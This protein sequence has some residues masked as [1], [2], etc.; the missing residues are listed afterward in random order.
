MRIG[1][2][3]RRI[4]ASINVLRG[5]LEIWSK[6]MGEADRVLD[7][8]GISYRYF[9]GMAGIAKGYGKDTAAICYHC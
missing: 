2:G 9:M 7:F 4:L 1:G 3:E 6:L 5:N 8:A